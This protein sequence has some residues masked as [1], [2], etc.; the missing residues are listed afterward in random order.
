M[1]EQP[2]KS[3]LGGYFCTIINYFLLFKMIFYFYK[4]L[5]QKFLVSNWFSYRATGWLSW[6]ACQSLAL[7]KGD[8]KL[9]KGGINFRKM[10][11]FLRNVLLSL[12]IAIL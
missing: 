5:R 2:T 4:L 7:G 11:Y 9:G 6:L 3:G 10:K 1:R 8:A 12:R